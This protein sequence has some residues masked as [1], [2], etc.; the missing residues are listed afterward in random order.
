REKHK[1][2]NDSLTK[3]KKDRFLIL[4]N[5]DVHTFDYVIDAL[6]D[7]CQHNTIQAEQCT[8]IIHFKGKCSVK[9]GKYEQLRS[10]KEAFIKKELD[11]TID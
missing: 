1:F 6:I 3:E 11:A 7:V 8:M 5:D 9:E 2:Q 10:M 4:H